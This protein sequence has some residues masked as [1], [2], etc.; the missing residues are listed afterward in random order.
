MYHP[1]DEDGMLHMVGFRD[2]KAFFRNSFIRTD[3]FLS[4]N[5]AGEPLWPGWAEP[6]Q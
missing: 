1:F 5:I 4:E 6:V 3:G 2:G